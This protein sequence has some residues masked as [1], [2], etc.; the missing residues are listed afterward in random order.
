M[1][2]EGYAVSGDSFNLSKS[3]SSCADRDKEQWELNNCQA[4]LPIT[5]P[6]RI[7]LVTPKMVLRTYVGIEAILKNE[8]RRQSIYL[9]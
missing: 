8:M 6:T 5:C 1:Q 3:S 7:H 4:G 9:N 2:G